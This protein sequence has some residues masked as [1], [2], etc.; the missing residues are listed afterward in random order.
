[1]KHLAMNSDSS[2]RAL[3]DWAFFSSFLRLVPRRPPVLNL[4]MFSRLRLSFSFL[5][6][7]RH[8]SRDE[9]KI[10]DGLKLRRGTK[11]WQRRNGIG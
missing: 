2:C 8:A 7:T 9:E 11:A 3:D 5:A 4:R 6:L 10:K 1:M